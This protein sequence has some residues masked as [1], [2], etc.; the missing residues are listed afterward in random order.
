MI[1]F[2]IY[3][4][5]A[6]NLSRRSYYLFLAASLILTFNKSFCSYSLSASSYVSPSSYYFSGFFISSVTFFSF[7]FCVDSS[8]SLF[9]SSRTFCSF[10]FFSRSYSSNSFCFASSSFRL[11]S[12]SVWIFSYSLSSYRIR[13]CRS[14]VG[15]LTSTVL[16]PPF[17]RLQMKGSC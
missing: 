12:P 3:S 8:T 14:V 13:L 15:S 9:S 7:V 4:Y 11:V 5:Y 2:F 1:S 6:N 10:S 16:L 17:R